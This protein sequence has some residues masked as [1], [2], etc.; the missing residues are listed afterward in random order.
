MGDFSYG[1]YIYGFLVGQVIAAVMPNIGVGALMALSLSISLL[2]GMLSWKFVERPALQL[3]K[4][5]IARSLKRP[6]PNDGGEL[7]DHRSTS[8]D[9]AG[10]VAEAAPTD[11]RS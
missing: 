8:A 11:A 5:L 6:E 9:S 1:T 3:R 7:S 2:C 10:L 4:T